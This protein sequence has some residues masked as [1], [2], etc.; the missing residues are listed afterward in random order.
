[1]ELQLDV[2]FEAQLAHTLGRFA[3]L[4]VATAESP[5]MMFYLDN[6]QSVSPNAPQGGQRQALRQLLND[7]P[8]A[9]MRR[10]QRLGA[11][12]LFGDNAMRRQQAMQNQMPQQQA[13]A[14]PQQQQQKRGINENYAREL[15]ELH[16]LGVDGGY[17]QKDVQ[18]VARCFTGW[19][20]LAPR[21][22]PPALMDSPMAERAG[23]FIFNP[24]QHD[25]G[26]KLVL[27]HK[28]PAGGGMNDG[29]MVLDIL[30][31]H[32]ATAKFIATKL[33][34]KFVMD[35]PTPELV[36]RVANAFTK[37]D[38]DIRETLRAIFAS[39]EFNA[40]ENF[41][42]KIKTPFELAVSAVR[43]LGGDTNGGPQLHQWIAR[44]G[45]PLYQYQP[46]TGYPDT[47][48]QWV[49]TGAL[50]E[51]INFALALAGNRI[52]GTRVDLA[53]FVGPSAT[54]GSKVDEARVLDAFVDVILQGD[55]TAQTKTSLLKKLDEAASAPPTTTET[56]RITAPS[57]AQAADDA[58]LMNGGDQQTRRERLMARF[59]QLAVVN[60][61]PVN[62]E[63][64]RIA[65]L[66]LG[67]PE[68][69]RQ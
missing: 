38:G 24:R 5:A 59:G 30:A 25:N 27:G 29:L 42:A 47:A 22:A 50:L 9:Q 66:I 49:N 13:Q 8:Q 1:M 23:T 44:M 45:E 36:A 53:R 54:P 52:P 65:A 67:S 55:M 12:G 7:N 41:R 34:R 21:G 20:I 31:H 60:A 32:P 43:A 18:E 33:C 37:S 2:L 46:P 39:P 68:F 51:R 58:A 62:Q 15:M 48:E 4:L 11:G 10:Q 17:T 56:A 28:I 57:A 3:D 14:R 19:T 63:V 64:A 26:E 69:Q 16:T 6:F 61:P 35:N 40:P